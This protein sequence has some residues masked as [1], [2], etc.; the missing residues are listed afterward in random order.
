[1]Q[2]LAVTRRKTEQFDDNAFAGFT[3]VE[4][5]RV[6]TLYAAGFIRQIWR[7]DDIKGACILTEAATE[8]DVRETLGTLPLAEAGMLEFVNIIPLAPY[9]GFGPRQ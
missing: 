8:A 4:S 9:P 7:R 5:E 6:R 2:F 1:M 3:E